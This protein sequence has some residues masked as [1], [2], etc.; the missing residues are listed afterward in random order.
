MPQA[1]IPVPG[2]LRSTG[3]F[4]GDGDQV[5]L[6]SSG[7][8]GLLAALASD[9]ELTVKDFLD[10]VD[11][12]SFEDGVTEERVNALIAAALSHYST[13]VQ[14]NAAI[15][16]ALSLAL[17]R[18]ESWA[19]VG[20]VATIPLSKI[21][22]SI[23]RLSSIS[24]WAQAGNTDPI[25][26]DKLINAP[27]GGGGGGDVPAKLQ[28]LDADI[29]Q[30]GD[31]L[32][33]NSSVLVDPVNVEGPDIVDR[34]QTASFTRPTPVSGVDI[35]TSE[36][37]ALEVNQ[38]GVIRLSDFVLDF[39]GPAGDDLT[40][41]ATHLLIVGSPAGSQNLVSVAGN[42]DPISMVKDA[43]IDHRWHI[44]WPEI[45][46]GPAELANI[47]NIQGMVRFSVSLAS[48]SHQQSQVEATFNSSFSVHG[49]LQPAI[50]RLIQG[51][52][53]G[54][55]AVVG[56]VM[57]AFA[58]K[59][60]LTG[61]VV[62]A[63]DDFHIA[64][65][66]NFGI[67]DHSTANLTTLNV[68]LP[69]HGN[70]VNDPPLDTNTF[71]NG[72]ELE[73]GLLQIDAA[74]DIAAQDGFAP[75]KSRVLLMHRIGTN[76]PVQVADITPLFSFDGG[77]V[78]WRVPVAGSFESGDLF[79]RITYTN[80]GDRWR[81]QPFEVRQQAVGPSRA[82]V[83]E[84]AHSVFDSSIA[85]INTAINAVKAS[86]SALA[87]TVAGLGRTVR[88]NIARLDTIDA[89]IAG[90]RAILGL[91]TTQARD[92]AQY[93]FA[94]TPWAVRETAAAALGQNSFLLSTKPG[95][96]FPFGAAG[97]QVFWGRFRKDTTADQPFLHLVRADN[98]RT[99]LLRT[100]VTSDSQGF[101]THTLQWARRVAAVPPVPGTPAGR[102]LE[103]RYLISTDGAQRASRDSSNPLYNYSRLS[104]QQ[105]N[106]GGTPTP[107]QHEAFI[108]NPPQVA[109][110][111]RLVA[112][113]PSGGHGPDDSD[114]YVITG[115]T[116]NQRSW[117]GQQV[118]IQHYGSANA[119][120]FDGG[121]PGGLLADNTYTIDSSGTINISAPSGGGPMTIGWNTDGTR[122]GI[123]ITTD[124]G[125]ASG[126]NWERDP[127]IELAYA[128]TV[129]VPA[130]PPVPGVPEH[131]EWTDLESFVAGKFH[132]VAVGCRNINNRAVL[133]VVFNDNDY[134]DLATDYAI[135]GGNWWECGDIESIFKGHQ[136]GITFDPAAAVPAEYANRTAYEKALF[137]DA[138]LHEAGYTNAADDDAFLGRRTLV[139]HGFTE[140]DIA[141]VVY[142]NNEDGERR[143]LLTTDDG[144]GG[145]GNEVSPLLEV[146]WTPANDDDGEQAVAI[147]PANY[148]D[149]QWLTVTLTNTF[150]GT[151]T[152]RSLGTILIPVAEM[153]EDATFNIHA[154]QTAGTT[155]PN[156]TWTRATRR[157]VI[158]GTSIDYD[159][160]TLSR[161]VG[162]RGPAGPARPAA[163]FATGEI[164]D[165]NVDISG[166]F[167]T[168]SYLDIPVP[169]A[170][171][172]LVNLGRQTSTGPES[173]RWIVVSTDEIRGTTQVADS[174]FT[175]QGAPN[176]SFIQIRADDAGDR[177]IGYIGWSQNGNLW[178]QSSSA[179]DDYMPLQI[180]RMLGGTEGPKG[181]KGDPP[182]LPS[183]HG[184][185][186]QQTR[187]TAPITLTA[188]QVSGNQSL[189]L[190]FS[191]GA[192]GRRWDDVT[193]PL[194][195]DYIIRTTHQNGNESM[196][197]EL[198]ALATNGTQTLTM[199][200]TSIQHVILLP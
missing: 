36:A 58:S 117:T 55:G 183:R 143:R 22:A 128:E 185:T 194:A 130:V 32:T 6:D 78:Q 2:R 123:R 186:I 138:V 1:N 67:R 11:A 30:S 119:G 102:R 118:R 167:G 23:A 59:L 31:T 116:M 15:G 174:G 7:L 33:F 120:P 95:T 99:Q 162:P 81:F 182:D 97:N 135:G 100:H 41:F 109:A 163:P 152:I 189:S 96:A 89:V 34:A 92:N 137:N 91:F 190:Q 169:E 87:D 181:D 184:T 144:G 98:D 142:G 106:P 141:A 76:A 170:E 136:Q 151:G 62:S 198:S 173:G 192:T 154:P 63:N 43:N 139:H 25:P 115:L 148:A 101:L 17:G 161:V 10:A 47:R 38:E 28:A 175:V 155:N 88:D 158:N 113:W 42:R 73:P 68:L 18:I 85:G 74:S 127:C 126:A 193:L 156:V 77:N 26:A 80:G 52:L 51:A 86:V 129:V 103:T 107:V 157:L 82:I 83:A 177:H 44:T 79:F 200:G 114:R 56:P 197:T 48:F 124:G 4:L 72:I 131:T 16:S 45:V 132:K 145:G 60:T 150:V 24:A 199:G 112:D 187:S 13:S 3:E 94:T 147:L 9:E 168:V 149:Y 5:Y 54:L 104:Q 39:P 153:Q 12:L 84:I 108:Y 75:A 180:R 105:P 65:Q 40:A 164:Y 125:G 159:R 37:A 176:T 19:M 195:Q 29:T 35:T 93:Q 90:W 69:Q 172:W 140:L 146:T 166:L 49:V 53:S 66:G 179:A 188:A 165:A 50:L 57:Q 21:P 46:V 160:I 134:D 171:W 8:T 61:N 71:A 178:I 20:N 64:P 27:G 14:M 122:P 196:W 111:I 110:T 70:V 121:N 191:N 133:S